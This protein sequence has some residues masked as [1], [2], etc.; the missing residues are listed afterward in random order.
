MHPLRFFHYGQIE[1]PELETS[2]LIVLSETRKVLLGHLNGDITTHYSAPEPE[3]L[4]EAAN[5][6]CKQKSG[7][8]FAETESG[9][10]SPDNRLFLRC[11]MARPARFDC[12]TALFAAS[13]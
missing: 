5:R 1:V 2:V 13:V 9:Y 7:T 10:R 3:E 12:A 4:I 11:N 8:G 6:V